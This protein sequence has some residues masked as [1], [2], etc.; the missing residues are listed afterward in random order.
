SLGSAH[1]PAQLVPRTRSRG[2]KSAPQD[3]SV[4]LPTIISAALTIEITLGAVPSRMRVGLAIQPSL[5]RA[6]RSMAEGFCRASVKRRY[7]WRSSH[8]TRTSL[9]YDYP[10]LTQGDLRWSSPP[11]LPD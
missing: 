6:A 1:A 5:I 7:V 11:M 2:R 9:L 8:T 4:W 10:P 3:D